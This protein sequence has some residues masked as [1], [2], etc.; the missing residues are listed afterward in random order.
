MRWTA[1]CGF[2]TRC[3]CRSD[4][5]PDPPLGSIDAPEST[6]L[7]RTG[8]VMCS[9]PRRR[10]SRM[11]V[12]TGTFSPVQV[13]LLGP[14]EPVSSSGAPVELAGAKLRGIL[15]V[16]ALEAGATV[17][18]S[19]LVEVLWDEPSGRSTNALQVAISKLRRALADAGEPDR[20]VTHPSGYQLDV[21]SESVD[22]LRFERLLREASVPG[23]APIDSGRA[24]RS[25]AGSVEGTGAGR[26]TR[27]RWGALAPGSAGRAPA[28]RGR[29]RRRYGPR[30]GSAR[31]T[32]LRHRD[33]RRGGATPRTAVGA[34][35][36]RRSTDRVNK[37]RRCGRLRGSRRPGRRD[38]R[39]A[40]R[41]A[42][43][44]RSRGPRPR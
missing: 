42:P 6:R 23:I 41:R 4:V 18:P 3:T 13:Q 20:V 37:R 27:Y 40:G 33:A 16:L 21:L 11:R 15:A 26:R 31:T 39:R 17:A 22:A 38:R 36:A 34:A 30:A 29:G 19:R 24:A 8:V 43:P 1:A 2:S 10:H 7:T 14:I 32:C 12:F 25:C 28:R 35:D 5:N 9:T 44:A